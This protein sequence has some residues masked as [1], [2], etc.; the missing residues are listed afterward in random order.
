M[1]DIFIAAKKVLPQQKISY[2]PVSEKHGLFNHPHIIYSFWHHPTGVTFEDQEEDEKLLLLLRRHLNTNLRWIFVTIVLLIIPILFIPFSQQLSVF[3][4]LMLPARFI[5]IFI[6]FY[7]MVVF[8][9]A[10]INFITWYFNISL[11]TD[12]RII[13]VDFSNLVYKNV[14]ATKISLLQ[15]AS[16]VQIGFLRSFFDYG[17]VLLQTA[18][19]LDNF[20]FPGVPKPYKVV[21]I[22]EELIG[23]GK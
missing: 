9:Y 8:T 7:Y 3:N 18:G 16:Y 12:K 15:D 5:V 2:K 21:Q 19:T 11:V 20:S 13:D 17:D 6:L 14:S 10:F 23:K 22:V 1:V 4:F